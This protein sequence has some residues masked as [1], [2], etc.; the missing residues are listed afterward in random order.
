MNN[1][2][3]YIFLNINIPKGMIKMSKKLKYNLQ[4]IERKIFY[5]NPKKNLKYKLV[6]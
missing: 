4:N 2:N 1:K 3:C 6:V 5:Q